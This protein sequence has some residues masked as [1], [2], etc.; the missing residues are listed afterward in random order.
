MA[1][2]IIVAIIAFLVGGVYAIYKSAKKFNLTAEQLKRIK[3]RNEELDKK[4]KSED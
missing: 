3:E 4:E 1:T 2:W